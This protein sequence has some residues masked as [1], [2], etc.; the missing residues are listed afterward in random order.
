MLQKTTIMTRESRASE[1]NLAYGVVQKGRRKEREMAMGKEG[2][3]NL[4]SE[5][6]FYIRVSSLSQRYSDTNCFHSSHELL[7]KTASDILR[8]PT[9][10][11]EGVASVF[12]PR[13]VPN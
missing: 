5:K 13:C 9:H 11:E 1:G 7:I 4:E 12:L 8:F 2:D 10:S 6:N 3:I